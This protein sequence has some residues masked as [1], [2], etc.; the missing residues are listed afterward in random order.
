M[1]RSSLNAS[2]GVDVLQAFRVSSPRLGEDKLTQRFTRPWRQFPF[3]ERVREGGGISLV[4]D[5]D[6]G[7]GFIAS[8]KGVAFA[9]GVWKNAGHLMDR[10]VH[11]FGLHNQVSH[12]Q[13]DV[14]IGMTVDLAIMIKT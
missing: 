10:Q 7:Y 14:M 8:G 12:G 2:Q 4:P 13:S 1:D 3:T 11:G 6:P 9:N 5:G